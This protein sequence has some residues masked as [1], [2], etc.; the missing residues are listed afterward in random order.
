M[1]VPPEPP[2]TV[3]LEENEE[4]EEDGTAS[5]S[6][7]KEDFVFT[8]GDKNH[9]D[10]DEEDDQSLLPIEFDMIISETTR[11]KQISLT[12]SNHLYIIKMFSL[13]TI[14]KANESK[15]EILHVFFLV[16][17]HRISR[18]TWFRSEVCCFLALVFTLPRPIC[19][20]TFMRSLL[21][22]RA[23]AF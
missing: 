19:E 18:R 13:T 12:S 2:T 14:L 8:I 9:N 23:V 22:N 3:V 6:S 17:I 5:S 21:S 16:R 11:N 7:F 15:S 4:E 20:I 10:D 1:C